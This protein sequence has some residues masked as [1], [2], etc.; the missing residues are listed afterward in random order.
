MELQ[1]IRKEFTQQSTI[2][3]LSVDGKFECYT[4]EDMVRPVKVTGM[5]AIPAG[6]YEVV[7]TFSARFQRPMPLLLDV[8]GYDGVRIHTGNTDHDT[9]GCILVGQ[10]KGKDMI[11]ASRA[12]FEAL[13]PKIQAAAQREKIF[14]HI[15]EDRGGNG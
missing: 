4:L 11:Q 8:P 1:V 15:I 13:F 6:D 10:I 7:V 3:E 12:A 5:T 9:E 14:I 2:G